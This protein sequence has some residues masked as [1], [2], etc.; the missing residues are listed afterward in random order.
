MT[1]AFFPA[2][3]L[4][5]SVHFIPTNGMPPELQIVMGDTL[6]LDDGYA[7]TL[8]EPVRCAYDNMIPGGSPA[9]LGVDT[10]RYMGRL[11]APEDECLVP[12]AGVFYLG[13]NLPD[14]LSRDTVG[15]VEPPNRVFPGR[16]VQ[17]VVRTDDSYIGYIMELIN[18]P[19]IMTPRLTP[20]GSH[21]S[22]ARLGTDC[23]GMAV[24]GRRRMGH[25]VQYLG[26]SGITRYLEEIGNGR[27]S[28]GSLSGNEMYLNDD[29]TSMP[30]GGDGLL[31]GDILH[32][33]AQVSV[34]YLDCG[35]IG[36]LDPEDLVIQSWFDGPHICTIRENGFFPHPLR[37]Y[38]WRE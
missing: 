2:L 18:T 1:G 3:M 10:L 20:E 36:V 4:S 6:R 12:E 11:L 13:V 5:S 27:F 25:P 38:R 28:P 34:F 31:P 15:F 26:P 8:L 23:A 33:H 9:G 29:G 37:V 30:V 35:S 14:S 16:L 17:I 22:D 24:Y 32:F 7:W 19:F 21:Q